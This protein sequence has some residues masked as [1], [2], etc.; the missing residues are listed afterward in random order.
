MPPSRKILFVEDDKD[1]RASVIDLLEGTGF[2]F[3]ETASVQA[4]LNLLNE[5]PDVQVIL[6]DLKLHKGRGTQLLESIKDK[7]ANYRVII[8][9]AHEE[10]LEAT[11]AAAY[12]V[13]SYVAKTHESFREALLFHINDAFVALEKPWLGKKVEAHLEIVRRINHLGLSANADADLELKEVLALIC[14]RALEILDAYTCHIRILDPNRG[15]LVLWASRGQVQNAERIFD[16]RVPL[17]KAYSGLAAEI[18]KT[19]IID[20]LQTKPEFQALKTEMLQD[21]SINPECVEYLNNVHAAYIVPI[22]TRVFGEDIDAIFN[23]NSDL[24]AFFESDEKKELVEEFMAQTA[25]AITKYLLKKKRLE[26]HSDYRNIGDMLGDISKIFITSEGQLEKI[27]RIIFQKISEGLRPEIISIFLFDETKKELKN[28]AEF[29]AG[30]WVEP[31]E[32]QYA[33]EVGM[34]GKAYEKDQTKLYN[35]QFK[36]TDNPGDNS[37]P[38]EFEP[39]PEEFEGEDIRDIPSGRLQHYLAVPIKVGNDKIGVIRVVNKRSEHYDLAETKTDISCLLKRG[40]SEDCRTELEIA[41]NHL[42]ATIKNAEL[43]GELNRTVKQLESLYEV[44]DM[45]VYEHDMKE[46]FKLIVERAAEVMHAELCMLFLKNLKGDRVE[47]TES[48]GMP[49]ELLKDAYYELG[50]GKTG[51]V[52]QTGEVFLEGEAVST[53]HGKY[54]VEI[55]EF[56]HRKHNDNSKDIESFMAVPI[57]AKKE[58]ILGVIKVINKVEPMSQTSRFDKKDLKRFEMFAKQI[59]LARFLH[60]QK[61]YLQNIVENSPVPII[62]LDKNGDVEIFNIACEQLWGHKQEEVRGKSVVHFYASE[63]EARKL[64]KQLWQSPGHRIHNVEAEIKNVDGLRIPVLLSATFLFDE[65]KRRIGSMGVFKDLREI[66]DYQDQ[67]QRA[68]WEASIGKYAYSISHQTQGNIATAKLYMDLLKGKEGIAEQDELMKYCIG[69][70]DALAKALKNLISLTR[71]PQP[72]APQ[73]ELVP[74]KNIFNNQLFAELVEEA[75]RQRVD[76]VYSYYGAQDEVL[77][78]DV[79]QIGEVIRHLFHNSLDAIRKRRTPDSAEIKGRIEVSAKSTDNRLELTWEDNGCGI[80]KKNLGKIFKLYY[81][82]GKEYG[83]GVGL[84]RVEQI[85]ENHDGRVSVDSVEGE[86]TTFSIT[87]PI[88][89]NTKPMGSEP[90]LSEGG[91]V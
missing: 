57:F 50:E 80:A 54:D 56:L 28:V 76:F 55:E 35:R 9:T 42:G 63:E 90:K 44:G 53:Y 21:E 33:P 65:E 45:L 15:D 49:M 85:I 29:R 20:D 10:L 82:E 6:L 37:Q 23:I 27:Y 7:I 8:L 5:H 41:A 81:T 84:Y 67:V 62:F 64:G 32:K 26:I 88:L 70:E 78:V 46:M 66:K 16:E 17:N 13:F 25:L 2:E 86:G 14:D 75:Y 34:V 36:S 61:F 1:Y 51:L 71:S 19:I 60:T 31:V 48:Y 79:K 68:E 43:I 89:D 39:L 18:G 11:E 69:V 40:F 38:K 74:V 59:G 30:Q 52:A 83:T 91:S 3:L 47:L 22:S 87:L 73:T 24:I 58:D 72:D 77:A 12:N 4:A